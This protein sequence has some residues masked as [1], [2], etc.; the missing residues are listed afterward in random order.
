[1]NNICGQQRNA[2][3]YSSVIMSSWC[4]YIFA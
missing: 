1:L 3:I 4:I 2:I